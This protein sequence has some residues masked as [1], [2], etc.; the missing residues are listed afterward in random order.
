MFENIKDTIS[1]LTDNEKVQ[2][3]VEKAK[4]FI[5]TDE[6]RE[7]IE[8]I[9]DKVEDFVSDKTNGNGIFGFGKK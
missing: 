2:E 9:K 1:N 7:K 8:E 4:A 5:N 3:T 6:G